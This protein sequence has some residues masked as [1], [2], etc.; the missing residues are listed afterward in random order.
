[1]VTVNLIDGYFVE[2]DDMNHTL[3]KHYVGE[4]KDGNRRLSEK[5]VGYFPDLPSCIERICRNMACDGNGKQ[6]LTIKEYAAIAEA[7]FKRCE[8]IKPEVVDNGKEKTQE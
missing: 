4:D 2:I 1:M 8:K 5:T 3:K 7:C 6:I